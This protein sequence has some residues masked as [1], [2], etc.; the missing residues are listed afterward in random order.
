MKSLRTLASFIF[1]LLITPSLSGQVTWVPS[2]STHDGTPFVDLP[3]APGF[4]ALT[5]A[6]PSATNPVGAVFGSNGVWAFGFANTTIS[7]TPTVSET[8]LGASALTAG[9]NLILKFTKG[10]NDFISFVAML[11]DAST[12]SNIGLKVTSTTTFEIKATIVDPIISASNNPD[13]VSSAFGMVIQTVTSSTSAFNF[14]GT[15]FVTNIHWNDLVP[16]NF[17]DLPQTADD[18][19]GIA[20]FVTGITAN[21]IITGSDTTKADFYA[22]MPE[23]FFEFA[24]A[25]GVDVTGANCLGYRT[26]EQLGLNQAPN[27]FFKM[28]DPD[29]LAFVDSNFDVD[30]N[31][32]ADSIWRFRIHNE[33]WS[34][35]S[36]AFGKLDIV[37]AIED[38]NILPT[39]FSIQ[40]NFPNPFNPSTTIKFTIPSESK[41]LI[42][43]YNS[44]GQTVTELV[45][46]TFSAGSYNVKF[47]A[48]NITSGIYFYKIIAQAVDGQL[49][50]ATKKMILLK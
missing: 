2:T 47:N 49:F 5:V 40:Q 29:T 8:D 23:K 22:Y 31:S 20:G 7:N 21:G 26:F 13:A 39:A 34:T 4:G 37:T 30:G 42:K 3:G 18:T 38:E 43:I 6:Q 15:V 50:T 33:K 32:L 14:Q 24:R 41:V 46:Q 17:N 35:E 12:L 44:L 10:A 9:T 27:G 16:P 28:N 19:T 11:A 45:N 1:I 48:T 25:N 36:I